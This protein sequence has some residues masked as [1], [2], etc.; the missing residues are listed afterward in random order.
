MAPVCMSNPPSTL[1]RL[2]GCWPWYPGLSPWCCGPISPWPAGPWLAE[3]RLPPALGVGIITP[4]TPEAC[5]IIPADELGVGIIPLTPP[6]EPIIICCCPLIWNCI[7][8]DSIA[9]P[10]SCIC[11]CCC[12]CPGTPTRPRPICWPPGEQAAPSPGV[13][14]DIAPPC[15]P[16]VGMLLGPGV[17]IIPG[18]SIMPLF[19]SADRRSC[20]C[21]SICCWR[22]WA[23]M[24]CCWLYC[25]PWWGRRPSCCCDPAACCGMP[26]CMPIWC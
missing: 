19:F 12:C 1:G 2:S 13:G 8:C 22:C 20:C 23:I 21:R 6:E 14:I 3:G 18:V 24:C 17:G 26:A 16:G 25:W 7:P 9:W 11:C 10:C 4:D 15:I 5:T